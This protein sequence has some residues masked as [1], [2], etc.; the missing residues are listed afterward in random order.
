MSSPL[1]LFSLLPQRI[2]W[3]LK[4]PKSRLKTVYFF[5]NYSWKTIEARSTIIMK[6]DLVPNDSKLI[7]VINILT[8]VYFCRL[9]CDTNRL[10]TKK[11]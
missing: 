4:S 11:N 5:Q 3:P 1:E 7:F 10:S 2:L 8:V 9:F 6:I